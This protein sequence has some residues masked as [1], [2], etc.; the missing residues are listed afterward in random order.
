MKQQTPCFNNKQSCYKAIRGQ[1]TAE[2]HS[3][4][5]SVLFL[6]PVP[7][8]DLSSS[9]TFFGINTNRPNNTFVLNVGY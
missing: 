6:Y 4:Q 2:A 1:V 3:F 7:P 5:K 9:Q 8:V